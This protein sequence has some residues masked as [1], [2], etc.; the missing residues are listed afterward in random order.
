M[1]FMKKR[2][3]QIQRKPV[4]VSDIKQ[5]YNKVITIPALTGLSKTPIKS[6]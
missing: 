4:E 3:Y 2:S 5:N 1:A 6:I